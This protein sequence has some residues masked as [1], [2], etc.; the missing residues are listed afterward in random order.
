MGRSGGFFLD[1]VLDCDEEVRKTGTNQRSDYSDRDL[2][3]LPRTPERITA[4]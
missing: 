2:C 1:A 3:R 4:S